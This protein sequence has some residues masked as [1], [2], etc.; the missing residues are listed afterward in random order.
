MSL[1]IILSPAA[2]REVDA[3]ADWYE[4][5]AGLG[6]RFVTSVQ[7]TLDRIEQMP[8]LHPVIYKQVRRGRVTPFPY[9]ILY[10]IL[11]DRIEVIAVVHSRRHPSV[12]KDRA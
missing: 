2:E 6:A 4:Q 12:W 8:E 10:R 1:P 9:N 5:E 7:E 11:L 3:A